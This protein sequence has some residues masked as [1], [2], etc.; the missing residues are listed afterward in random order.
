MSSL[1][2]TF[3]VVRCNEDDPDP[4]LDLEAMAEKTSEDPK[5]LTLL[6]EYLRT[7]D[8]Q[9]LRLR[10]GQKPVWFHVQRLPATYLTRVLDAEPYP[11]EKLRLAVL[12]AVHLVET[13]DG[14]VR[15]TTKTQAPKG[16]T[17]WTNTDSNGCEVATSSWVQELVDRFGTGVVAELGVIAITLSRLPRGKRG[18]FGFWGGSVLTR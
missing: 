12:A 2:P 5:A 11:A 15:C 4:A 13:P 1:A 18:P 3:R 17:W 14:P 7:R 16:A 8:E 9:F 10:D 6:G